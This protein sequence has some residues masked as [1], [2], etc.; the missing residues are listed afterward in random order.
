MLHGSCQAEP[1]RGEGDTVGKRPTRQD[2]ADSLGISII[3]VHRALNDTGYVS[4]DLRERI[5]AE[6]ARIGYRPHRAAQSLVRSTSRELVV[7]S[8]ESPTF[9]WDAVERGVRTAGSQI[10][11]FGYETRYERISRGDTGAYLKSLRSAR[12]RGVSA[13]AVVNN[14]EYEM[15][16]VFAF[17][18]RWGVPYATLNIDAPT[19]RRRAF[20]GVDH[21]AEG[22]LAA[23][24]LATGAR[25]GA[26]VAVVS[27]LPRRATTLAGADIA[28]E[29]FEGCREALSS[30]VRTIC[31]PVAR[32]ARAAARRNASRPSWDVSPPSK[33]VASS[34]KL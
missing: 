26:L 31:L 32:L 8:T 2:I 18:D 24:F 30:S 4:I 15:E 12:R 13:V 29:R 22:R 33:A 19:S 1:T 5:H 6:A 23:D 25:R 17:L 16:A 34:S 10:A 11:D 20:V 21:A 9:H 14:L 3:T 27:G 28:A 7:F